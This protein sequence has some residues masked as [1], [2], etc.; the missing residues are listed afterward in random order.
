MAIERTWIDSDKI[1]EEHNNLVVLQ[2]YCWV[3]TTDDKVI[4]VSKDNIKWQFPGGHPE[5]G[6]THEQTVHRELMEET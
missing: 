4:L 5:E 1:K 3:S 2:I 6:E